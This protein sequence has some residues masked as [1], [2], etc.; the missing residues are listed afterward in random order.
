M[1]FSKLI[2]VCGLAAS[3]LGACATTR[4]ANPTT[5][6]LDPCVPKDPVARCINGEE[7]RRRHG[8]D[9]QAALRE[10]LFP[11]VE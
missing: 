6:E 10:A 4:P 3:L 7:L 2:L 11:W 9:T 1:R 8:S 5:A